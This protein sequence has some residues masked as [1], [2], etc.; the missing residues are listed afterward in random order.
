MKNKNVIQRL[1]AAGFA[2]MLMLPIRLA[3]GHKRKI[4]TVAI[5]MMVMLGG[6]GIAA[7]LITAEVT[8]TANDVTVIQGGGTVP[9]TILVSATGSISSLITSSSPSTAK[10]NTSYTFI[11]GALVSSTPSDPLNFFAGTSCPGGGTNCGVTWIGAPTPYIVSAVVSADASTIAGNYVITLSSGT[12]T[13]QETNPSVSGGKLGDI[14]ATIIN[15]HVRLAAPSGLAATGV[16]QTQ[17]NLAW[18]DN[19]NGEDNFAIESS[20]SAGGPFTALATVGAG[21]TSYSDSSLS[22]GTTRYYQVKATKTTP[23]GLDSDYSTVASAT[24]SACATPPTVT[25]P[26]NQNANEGSSTSFNLGSFSDPNGG[27]WQVT[28]NWGDSSSSTTF[29]ATSAGPLNTQTHTYADNGI[30]TV[31]VTVTDSTTLSDSKTFQVTVNNVAPTVNTPAIAPEPSV[32]GSSATASATFSDPGTNDAPFTCTVDYG[33][34]SGSLTGTVSG[35]T[36]TGPAH[37]YADNGAY[38][39]TVSVTDKDGGTGSGSTT[40][41]IDNVAPTIALSGA[42]NVEEG[43]SYTLDLGAITD[44]GTDTV[45][46]YNIN[47]GDGTSDTFSGSPAGLSKTHT[48]AD[49]PNSY[50]ITVDLTDEDDTFN[51]AGSKAVTVNNV[52]PTA[53]FNAPASVNEGSDISLSLTSPSDPSSADTAAGFQYAFDCGDGYGSFGSVSSAA[54]SKNDNGVHTVKGKIKDKDGGESEYTAAVTI[55]NVAPT[56]TPQADQTV[57]EGASTL[58]SLGSFSDPG[59]NDNPWTVDVDWGDGSPHT[60]FNMATQGALT[61]QSHTYADGPNSYTIAVKVT[62]KDGGSDT[63]TFKVTVNNVAPTATIVGAP[64]SSPEGTLISLSSTV[65][66]S[67][68]SDTAAGFT[69][70][71]SVTKNGNPFASGSVSSLSFTPDDNGS[72]V[73]TFTATDKDGGIGTDTKTIDV[74]NVAPTVTAPSDQIATQSISTSFNLGSFSDPGVNDNPWTVDVNWGDG[75]AKTTFN[76]PNQGTI[77]TQSHTYNSIGT[78]TVTVT[79]TDKDSGSNSKT[80]NVNVIYNWNGFFRPIDNLD[81]NG[82]LVLNVVKAGSAVPGKFSLSGDQG[83]GIFAPGYPKSQQIACDTNALQDAVNETV[84]AG[85]SGLQYDPLTDQYIYVWKTDKSWS[86]TCRQLQVKLID[87][88]THVANFKF[89][90]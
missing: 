90:K 43:S 25:A 88:T 32:E 53:T 59:I 54:C 12:G 34:S 69:Y 62:D 20:S 78:Y 37:T 27:S 8:G 10:V 66:D 35:T 33:D 21:V 15:L 89:T 18:T 76:M 28:V 49:G 83:L 24:T 14:D 39:V 60:T 9:S 42:T 68:T 7:E 2:I 41:N 67:S 85:S 55:N 73:V 70:A 47:W 4:S 36:C 29:T 6:I 45:G 30:Y 38:T 79:V 74:T 17:I 65:T 22:C 52:A 50:T 75:S 40:H 46:S 81:S 26:S 48:Y 51:A 31:T 1:V 56:V 23:S 71:L 77:T 11:G 80:F 61:G 84:T 87:G 16:S 13:T 72:Y 19:S 3:N 44:P 82:K 57:D 63:K 64:A 58:F 86:N 5:V